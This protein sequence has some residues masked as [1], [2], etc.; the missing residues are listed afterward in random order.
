[1]SNNCFDMQGKVVL[2][3]GGSR[4]LGRAMSLGLAEAGAD[5]IIASRKLENCEVVAAQVR[6][7][8]RRALAVA[9]HTGRLEDIDRLVDAAYAEFGR[10]DVLINNAG[11]NPAAGPIAQVSAEAFQKTFDVNTRGPWYLASKIAPRMGGHGGGA[12][13]NVISVSGIKASVGQGIYGASKAALLSMT[14]L[15]AVEWA[16]M[17]VR[18]NAI[19]PGSYHSDLMDGAIAAIPGF[20][21]GAKA[22]SLQKRI[23]DTDEIIGPI[24]YLASNA[25]AYTTGST[26]VT[27]GG[28]LLV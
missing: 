11:I 10:V 24:L 17:K 13:I 9:A 14:K 6:Q 21:E 7:K 19:A 16:P 25:S 26:L 1:M 28:Y 4:G 22:A 23:A 2:I 3:T 12:I 27:D 18:V 20:E 5:I 8:G 15:M